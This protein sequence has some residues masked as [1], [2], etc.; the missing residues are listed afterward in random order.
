M[1]VR[2]HKDYREDAIQENCKIFKCSVGDRKFYV[3]AKDVDNA[4]SLLRKHHKSSCYSAK[5]TGR[6]CI[7]MMENEYEAI[8]TEEEYKNLN[9]SKSI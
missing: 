9:N 4:V 5:W 6:Y 2:T 8:F 7:S 3:V 1:E